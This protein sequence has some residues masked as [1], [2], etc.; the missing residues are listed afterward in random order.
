[1]SSV[2]TVLLALTSKGSP[3]SE[4][5]L[6]DKIDLKSYWNS[7]QVAGQKSLR[8]IKYIIT[9][10]SEKSLQSNFSKNETTDSASHTASSN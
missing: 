5:A 8:N 3:S 1:M 4:S 10:V 7:G 2:P 6:P 9:F